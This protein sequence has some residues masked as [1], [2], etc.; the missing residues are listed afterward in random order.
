MPLLK[1]GHLYTRIDLV[2][3]IWMVPN[4][5]INDTGMPQDIILPI[6]DKDN[7][8]ELSNPNRVYLR[9]PSRFY[10]LLTFPSGLSTY[11]ALNRVPASHGPPGMAFLI[12]RPM[13]DE[14]LLRLIIA[15]NDSTL[16]YGAIEFERLVMDPSGAGRTGPGESRPQRVAILFVLRLDETGKPRDWTCADISHKTMGTT[17]LNQDSLEGRTKI[18]LNKARYLEALGWKEQCLLTVP[19]LHLGLVALDERQRDLSTPHFG[20]YVRKSKILAGLIR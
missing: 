1:D 13:W 2:S 4:T 19:T 20:G 16:A 11:R 9:Q 8:N 3:S 15:E 17:L 7:K 6:H 10:I 12:R 14:A 5:F 18:G